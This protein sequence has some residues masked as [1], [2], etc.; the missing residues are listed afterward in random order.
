MKFK[1]DHV[2]NLLILVGL[3]VKINYDPKLYIRMRS[4]VIWRLDL[5]IRLK[6]VSRALTLM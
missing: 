6:R 4:V 3:A 1:V 2:S 5:H